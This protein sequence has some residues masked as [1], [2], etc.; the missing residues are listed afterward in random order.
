MCEVS[1][2][3]IDLND[4]PTPPTVAAKL[5][6]T[7]EKQDV[8]TEEIIKIV[9]ADPALSAKLVEYCNSPM[10][11]RKH[12]VNSLKQ[13]VLTIGQKKLKLLALSFS[14]LNVEQDSDIDFDRFWTQSLANAL[15]CSL[16]SGALKR[17]A[18]ED[19]LMALVL[20]VGQI[21]LAKL[22]PKQYADYL[23][24]NPNGQRLVDADAVFAQERER[25]GCN[26]FEIGARI[27]EKWRFPESMYCMIKSIAE[28]K[29]RQLP[30]VKMLLFSQELATTLYV[31]DIAQSRIDEMTE[32]AGDLFDLDSDAFLEMIDELRQLWNEYASLLGLNLT[33]DYSVEALEKRARD[34]M[35][36]LSLEIESELEEVRAANSQLQIDSQVDSLT[37]LLNRRAFDSEAPEELASVRNKKRSFGFVILD[38]DHFKSVNDTY[39]HS[40][41]DAVL[42][43]V[44]ECFGDQR[45]VGR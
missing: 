24:V 33:C 27:L 2:P 36:S 29:H 41:G 9:A 21:G 14:L 44:G 22:Y 38:I 30:H 25:F 31:D 5:L 39:G 1:P 40:A 28:K 17:S 18:D 37:K 3:E 16:I 8:T 7:V 26:R 43:A 45:P 13:A 15:S 12:E 35:L 32:T 20:N 34:T 42:S 23:L 19:F 10:M 4:L 11:R 6:E